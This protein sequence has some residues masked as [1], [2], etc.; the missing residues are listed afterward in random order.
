[1]N[2]ERRAEMERR[3]LL[4]VIGTHFARSNAPRSDKTHYLRNVFS[5]FRV[6]GSG[7]EYGC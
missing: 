7:F 2:S 6:P 5:A 3:A 1:M 4:C